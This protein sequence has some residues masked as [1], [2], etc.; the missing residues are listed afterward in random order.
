VRK[1]FAVKSWPV[2]RPQIVVYIRR[3]HAAALALGVEILEQLVARQIAQASHDA[4][5]RTVVHGDRM[6][7]AGLAAEGEAQSGAVHIDMM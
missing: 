6:P 2:I 4:R 7:L 1:S 5:Q 3:I